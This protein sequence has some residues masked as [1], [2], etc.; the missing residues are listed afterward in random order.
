MDLVRKRFELVESF[1]PVASVSFAKLTDN[2][3]AAVVELA[4]YLELPLGF[5]LRRADTVR[6]AGG[7]DNFT[8]CLREAAQHLIAR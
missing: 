1:M 7:Q 6:L 8:N 3:K 2:E 5:L 4:D